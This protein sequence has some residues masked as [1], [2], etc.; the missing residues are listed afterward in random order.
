MVYA[1]WDT[2]TNNLVAEY[3]DLDQALTLV[4]RGIERNGPRDTDTLLLQAEDEHGKVRSIAHGQ[5]L[6]EL[7]RQQ[8]LDSLPPTT[9]SV[10]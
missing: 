6:A 4:R 7:A 5:Q 10:R 9:E 1:L 8:S 3:R 2:E